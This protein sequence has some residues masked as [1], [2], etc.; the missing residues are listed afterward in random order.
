MRL[1]SFKTSANCAAALLKLS[2]L[3]SLLFKYNCD[4]QRYTL[5]TLQNVYV[6]NTADYV[7]RIKVPFKSFFGVALEVIVFNDSN[8][9]TL[10]CLVKRLTVTQ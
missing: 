8:P 1:L 10:D 7:C 4:V 2:K 3:Y 5:R 6:I 9:V